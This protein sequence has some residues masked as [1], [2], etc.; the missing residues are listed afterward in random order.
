MWDGA[1]DPFGNPQFVSGGGVWGTSVWGSFTWGADLSL[2]NLR[3]PGQYIDGET[4]LNQNWFRDYDPT[5]GRYIQSDPI[6]LR[7]GTNTYAY[8]EDN[9]LTYFNS[10]GLDILFCTRKALGVFKLA[11]ANHGYLWDTRSKKACG[12]ARITW[13]GYD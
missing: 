12:R 10:K 11:N 2:T 3:F 7:A 4:A 6:G 9:P 1:F 13:H 8:V 5:M